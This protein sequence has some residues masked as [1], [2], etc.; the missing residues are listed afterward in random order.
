VGMHPKIAETPVPK[1]LLRSDLIV[2]DVVYNP[3]ETR[4]LREAREQGAKTVPGL[5]M[6]LNQAVLQFEKWTG[7]PAPA[8]IMRQVLEKNL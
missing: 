2:M 4:L 8:D 7:Q 3:R 5:E 6:F 1:K